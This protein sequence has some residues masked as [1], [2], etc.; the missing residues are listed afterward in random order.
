MN[1]PRQELESNMADHY[2]MRTGRKLEVREYG[3]SR[4]HPAFFFH[5]LIGSHHQASYVADQAKRAGLRII[6]PNRPGVGI[7]EFT[8]RTSPLDAVADVEDVALALGLDDFSV[9]GISGGTPYALAVLHQLRDRVRTVTVISGMG[10]MGMPGALEGMERRR[11]AFLA[12]GT[13]FPRLAQRLFQKVA[14][15]FQESPEGLLD[16]LIR[17]WSAADQK[18][19]QRRDVYDFFLR[20][21]HQVFTEGNGAVG[22]AHELGMYRYRGFPL[23]GLP[24]DKRIT[25]WHGLE[26]VIVPPAMTWK[27]VRSLPNSEAHFIP[28]GHFM[29]VD[30]APAIVARLRQQLDEP[31]GSRSVAESQE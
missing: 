6:A 9:I 23:A 3:D 14:A 20:D 1:S 31:A 7:S 28:G 8:L 29:A 12:I 11:R 30:A 22:L 10:P 25:L 19:F 5:G 4:G 16:R 17:T 15:R 21:L 2:L 24:R 26:D 27:M 13:R 18:V